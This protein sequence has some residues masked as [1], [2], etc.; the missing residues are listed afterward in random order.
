LRFNRWSL[1]QVLPF[2][3]W[4]TGLA[5]PCF[6]GFTNF[7][8][9]LQSRLPRS[10]S[11]FLDLYPAYSTSSVVPQSSLAIWKRLYHEARMNRGAYRPPASSR[12]SASTLCQKC[13][14]RDKSHLSPLDNEADI[15]ASRHFSY[16]CK[17]A[18]QERP[19]IARPSRTQQLL[20]PK[21]A[22]KLSS[23]VPNDFMQKYAYLWEIAVHN[24]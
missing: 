19:Y 2:R 10:R 8:F 3:A 4:I 20:N 5:S 18:A 24:D 15:Q 11:F 7:I 21:L 1:P 22:P 16:E 23:D 17:A 14:K 12:A 13:L 9:V 6:F